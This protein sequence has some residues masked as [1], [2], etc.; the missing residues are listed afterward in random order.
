M[1][2]VACS[3]PLHHEC[4][5][6]D[7]PSDTPNNFLLKLPS[8]IRSLR[9]D[10]ISQYQLD[11]YISS[12]EPDWPFL[13]FFRSFNDIQQSLIWQWTWIIDS[14]W[15]LQYKLRMWEHRHLQHYVDCMFLIVQLPKSPFWSVNIL[16]M[17]GCNDKGF[18]GKQKAVQLQVIRVYIQ[19]TREAVYRLSIQAMETNVNPHL[20]K[21]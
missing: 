14:E 5:V 16:Y 10:A 9:I 13:Y 3:I 15:T 8:E 11:R 17:E 1:I 19:P 6:E 21:N 2:H 20:S 7:E 4:L 18:C 12:N